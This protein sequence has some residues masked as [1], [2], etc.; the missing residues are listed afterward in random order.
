MVH[1][2]LPS[3]LGLVCSIWHVTGLEET[4]E[5]RVGLIHVSFLLLVTW[6]KCASVDCSNQWE[7]LYVRIIQQLLI[8]QPW[9]KIYLIK[10]PNL[11]PLI[12]LANVG[13]GA[14][15]CA[16]LHKYCTIILQNGGNFLPHVR[17][18]NYMKYMHTKLRKKGQL[19]YDIVQLMRNPMH[20]I[21]CVAVP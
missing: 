11:F 18:K 5:I 6:N 8:Y 19:Q 7:W 21:A 9:T 4:E 1:L 3:W 15:T 2:S 20:C 13:N 14:T 12:Y 10:K 16:I 17:R